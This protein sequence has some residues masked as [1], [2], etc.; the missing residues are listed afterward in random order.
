MKLLLLAVCD[1]TA[2]KDYKYAFKMCLSNTWDQPQD[3]TPHLFTCSIYP[4][5]TVHH[6]IFLKSILSQFP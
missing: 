4:R 6:Y 5:V 1:F 2:Y 3:L